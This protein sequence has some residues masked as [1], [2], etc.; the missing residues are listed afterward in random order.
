MVVEAGRRKFIWG[1]RAI[2]MLV[3]AAIHVWLMLASRIFPEAISFGDLSLYNF[4]VYQIQMGEPVFGISQDWVYPVLALL[5]MVAA[6][7]ISSNFEISWVALTFFVGTI[8][9]LGL[10]QEDPNGKR[11]AGSAPAWLYLGCLAALGPVAISRIDSISAALSLFGLAAVVAGRVTTSSIWFTIAGWMKI[12]PIA[13]FAAMMASARK[14]MM[15]ILIAASVTALI[16]FGTFALGGDASVLSFLTSQQSRG[17]QIES[18]M[19]TP[20]LWLAHFGSAEIYFDETFITNQVR[21][22][23]TEIFAALSTPGLLLA[24][25][26]TFFLALRSSKAGMDQGKV[27]AWAAI[28]GVTDLIVFNKVGSPQFM[29]WLAVPLIAA[30]VFGLAERWFLVALGLTILFFTQLIYPVFYIDLLRLE[31]GPVVLI[32]LRNLLLVLLLVVGNLGLSGK[33]LFQKRRD[34][35]GLN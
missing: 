30:V 14:F 12:W 13:L 18:V 16:L 23:G 1:E 27:F 9:A 3:S 19:A 25:G 17:I 28:T 33:K 10:W 6:S 2:F 21:G 5:P 35:V 7:V 4:W 8:G 22:D 29:I 20:W 26:I 24:L 32:S 34:A 31:I 11:F 15:P